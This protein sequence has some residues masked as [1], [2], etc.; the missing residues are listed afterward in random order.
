[1]GGGEINEKARKTWYD[2]MTNHYHFGKPTGV[3]QGYEAGGTVPDPVEGYGLAIQY[4]NTSFGQGMTATPLQMAGA[5]AS[6]INGGTYYR[7]RLV[8]K[9]IDDHGQEQT[10]KPDVLTKDV[11]KPETSQAL[12]EMMEYTL[13]KNRYTPTHPGIKMGGKTGTAQVANPNGGYYDD[14][15]NG[16]FVGFVGVDVPKYVIVVR[17]NEPKIAGYAGSR[18]AA[19]LFSD[20]AQMI[21]NNFPVNAP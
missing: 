8:E 9:Y 19:P 4:A 15:F 20:V 7:P 13:V 2:Y 12:R 16:M 11:V 10:V 17:V 21:I 1:M 14:R 5:M 18:A 6:A 3:E